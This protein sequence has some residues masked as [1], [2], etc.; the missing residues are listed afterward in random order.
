MSCAPTTAT[1]RRSRRSTRS[2]PVCAGS[3]KETF[4]ARGG[5]GDALPGAA[6]VSGRGRV[7]MRF[8]EDDAGELYI[9]TKSDGM[10]RQVVGFKEGE[11]GV[12]VGGPGSGG[13]GFLRLRQVLR[14]LTG[15]EISDAPYRSA[16]L[17][18]N[19]R[20]ASSALTS[21]SRPRNWR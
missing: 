17:P 4:R 21:G 8:A 6:A 20:L 5:R 15:S 12:R 7:D 9:L 1:R 2:T 16:L 19:P 3:S 13:S 11:S 10:I 14:G 18:G